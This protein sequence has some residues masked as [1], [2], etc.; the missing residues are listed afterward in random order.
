MDNKGD[1]K[2]K[3]GKLDFAVHQQRQR[4][5]QLPSRVHRFIQSNG[6]K[7]GQQQLQNGQRH[8]QSAYLT[9]Q[10]TSTLALTSTTMRRPQLLHHLALLPPHPLSVMMSPEMALNSICRRHHHPDDTKKPNGS[11]SNSNNGRQ[12]Q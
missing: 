5:Q 9:S 2:C 6:Q 11:N 1:S 12:Y 3:C 8:T 10:S 4:R 7:K